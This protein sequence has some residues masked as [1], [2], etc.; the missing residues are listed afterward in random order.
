VCVVAGKQ[1]LLELYVEYCGGREKDMMKDPPMCTAVFNVI[2]DTV[3]GSNDELPKFIEWAAPKVGRWFSQMKSQMFG[4]KVRC[5]AMQF[6]NMPPKPVNPRSNKDEEGGDDE[7]DDDGE[8]GLERETEWKEMCEG[9]RRLLDEK[10]NCTDKLDYSLGLAKIPKKAG[11]SFAMDFICAPYKEE[12][13]PASLLAVT[14]V[15]AEGSEPGQA[16]TGL[17]VFG[18]KEW[19]RFQKSM[20]ARFK[21]ATWSL[22]LLANVL[23][24]VSQL[25]PPPHHTHTR[26]HL[27]PCH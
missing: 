19:A 23:Y 24:H 7:E 3:I 25:L 2:P 15:K 20:L 9:M 11:Q 17:E 8:A 27:P 1:A 5:D 10:G 4:D 12:S 18:S 22:G 16:T 14:V 6:F 26:T 21:Q 13:E